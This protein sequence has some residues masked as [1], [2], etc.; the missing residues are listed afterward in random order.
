MIRLYNK[1][2]LS[3]IIISVISMVSCKNPQQK[4]KT[5]TANDSI[6]TAAKDNAYLN[7][8][9]YRFPTPDE[10]FG[11]INNEKLKFDQTL[12]NPSGNAEKYLSSKTQTIA[13]GV[14]IADLAYITLFE[15]YNKSIEYYKIIHSLSEKIRINSA[16]DL[17]ISK[18]IEKNLLN[19]DS[20]KNIS[21]DSYSSMVEF[22]IL[23]NR[24]KTLALIASGAYIECFYIAFNLAGNYSTDNPMILKI[25][26]L[27]FAFENLYSYLQIY[28]EDETIKLV[29]KQFENLNTIFKKIK[30]KK[31]GKTTMKQDSNG[32][33]VLG[34]GSKLEIDNAIFLEL[35]HEIYSLH[36]QFTSNY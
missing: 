17:A 20:L 2:I 27:K 5:D 22:L 7:S 24:E 16:Y 4:D 18:R 15:S 21:V 29:A 26:D 12:L 25:V 30:E 3:I 9:Y 14:Y 28:S 10:I 34:G 36:N 13:L 19:L 35:K 8:V 23:N 11:F 1:N 31:I 32:N 33:F 6:Q